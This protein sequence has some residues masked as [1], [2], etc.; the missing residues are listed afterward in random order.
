MRPDGPELIRTLLTLGC[1]M[2]VGT[3]RGVTD[4][5]GRR[6]HAFGNS[7]FN[8]LYKTLFGTDFTDIFSGYRAFRA[9]LPRASRR[10]RAV[11]RSRP[12]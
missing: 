1:D 12:K 4:D 6:G 8:G 5:A 7:V 3:R 9:A 2:V 11:S 10:S